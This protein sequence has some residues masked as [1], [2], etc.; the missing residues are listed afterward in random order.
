MKSAQLKIEYVHIYSIV[1]FIY[2][3]SVHYIPCNICMH[4][5]ISIYCICYMH[6]H[7]FTSNTCIQL[8]RHTLYTHTHTHMHLIGLGMI[9]QES[10]GHHDLG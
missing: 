7:I 8:Y 4:V 6:V 10:P 3:Y 5:F 9:L 1:Y 2:Q